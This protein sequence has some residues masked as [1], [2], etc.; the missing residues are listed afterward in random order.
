MKIPCRSEAA[1]PKAV[2]RMLDRTILKLENTAG[3][4]STEQGILAFRCIK[5]VYL[6]YSTLSISLVPQQ[7]DFGTIRRVQL[8]VRQTTVHDGLA[9]QVKLEQKNGQSFLTIAS[10]G[11]TSLLCQNELAKGLIAK[12]SLDQ[13]MKDYY[14]FPTQIKWEPNTDTS[15]YIYDKE[16]DTMWDGV[17]NLCFKLN[18]RYPYIG[19]TNTIRLNL[20]VN[21]TVYPFMNYTI[22]SVGSTQD[23]RSLV[24]QYHMPDADG[25][26]DTFLLQNS[27]TTDLSIVRNRQI[28]FDMQ[29]L[30]N[31]AEALQFRM[32]YS[33]RGWKS[34]FLTF[35]GFRDG[36]QLNDQFSYAPLW[37]N[38]FISRM[39]ITGSRK[40]IFTKLF[41]YY[42]DWNNTDV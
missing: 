32:R 2:I 5:D 1:A 28:P 31:P 13:L 33:N 11:F 16:N 4:T 39:E 41:A 23:F 20:P 21:P 30:R 35:Y 34:Q 3:E 22:A 24:S 26:E 12:V 25:T 29:Y 27:K 42:D 17:S 10:R 19:S 36:L 18:G 7:T 8:T 15:N 38:R 6:P 14:P 9:D 37:S 40:G